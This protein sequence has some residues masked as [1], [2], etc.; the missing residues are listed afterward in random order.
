M[1]CSLPWCAGRHMSWL[2]FNPYAF[3]SPPY[4]VLSSHASNTQVMVLQKI[5][6]DAE[7]VGIRLEE[8]RASGSLWYRKGKS[9]V[10]MHQCKSS[11]LNS[12]RCSAF[13]DC[14]RT[15]TRCVIT[16]A[17]PGTAFLTR[18]HLRFRLFVNYDLDPYLLFDLLFLCGN[19]GFM[20]P[21]R[22]PFSPPRCF[23]SST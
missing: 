3:N 19:P 11:H 12:T 6:V 21:I 9:Q 10:H 18:L 14:T 17:A 8:V 7:A 4:P 22:P 16:S 20:V 13:W 2:H 23:C 15:L 1:R 5:S